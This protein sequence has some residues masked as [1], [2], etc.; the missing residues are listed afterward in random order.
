MFT[1]NIRG[2]LKLTFNVMFKKQLG[3]NL[4]PIT[5]MSSVCKVDPCH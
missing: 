3:Y 4:K 2:Y 1:Y 5:R